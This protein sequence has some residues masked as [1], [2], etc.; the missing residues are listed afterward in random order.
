VGLRS[1]LLYCV[2]GD[3]SDPGLLSPGLVFSG[4]VLIVHEAILTVGEVDQTTTVSSA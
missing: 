1:T 2:N 4:S 3:G